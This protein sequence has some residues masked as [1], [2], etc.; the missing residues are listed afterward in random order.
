MPCG[1]ALGKQ[2]KRQTGTSMKD[3]STIMMRNWN[4]DLEQGP[5]K[6]YT[7]DYT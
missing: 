6:V 2:Y 7:N 1:S 3:S 4:N 5:G